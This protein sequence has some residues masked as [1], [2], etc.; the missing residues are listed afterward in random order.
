MKNYFKSKKVNE[1]KLIIRLDN[2]EHVKIN[3][4][5]LYSIKNIIKTFLK[6]EFLSEEEIVGVM[7]GEGTRESP[8][9]I[10]ILIKS[11]LNKKSTDIIFNNITNKIKS[12]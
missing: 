5:F 2:H 12:L 9:V 7:K 11:N 10:I 3:K 6:E 1:Y 8:I 4:D